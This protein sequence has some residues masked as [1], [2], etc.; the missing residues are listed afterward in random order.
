[1][2]EQ[3]KIDPETGLKERTVD[4]ASILKAV[5]IPTWGRPKGPD[6]FDRIK[7]PIEYILDQQKQ[8]NWLYN[9]RMLTGPS[10]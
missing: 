9:R 10:T 8:E 6:L 7:E 4:I 5:N 3:P 1:M 2:S